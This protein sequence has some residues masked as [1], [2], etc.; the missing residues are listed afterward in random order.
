MVSAEHDP[1]HP[2]FGKE[3]LMTTPEDRMDT[4]ELQL[5]KMRRIIAA[6]LALMVLVVG[7]AA[8]SALQPFACS[9]LEVRTP[10]NGKLV[11]KLAENGDVEV[12]GTLKIKDTD[13]LAAIKKLEQD[14]SGSQIHISSGAYDLRGEPATV[15]KEGGF[16]HHI[17]KFDSGKITFDKPFKNVPRVFLTRSRD[18][19]AFH[20]GDRIF[21]ECVPVEVTNTDFR[22]IVR[23]LLPV[24]MTTNS[25]I[26][27]LAIGE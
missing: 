6:L 18:D 25:S 2:L 22:I 26:G 21:M 5:R 1:Y 17:H 27:W 9:S 15:P 3:W 16:A 14:I 11:T 4:F 10:P 20:G 19:I 8:Q 23:I 13:V 12:G 24:T 7:V